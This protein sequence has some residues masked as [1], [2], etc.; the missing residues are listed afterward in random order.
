MYPT[1]TEYDNAIYANT[2]E[3][4]GKIEF[5]LVDIDAYKDAGVITVTSENT[6]SKKDETNDLVRNMSGKFMTWE[7]DS[8]ILD[9]SI[10]LAPKTSETQ[11]Q[12]GWWSD[13]QSQ[14]DST[15]SVSQV[16]TKPFLTG[17]DSIGLTVIFDPQHDEYAEE[18]DI[19]VY[20][21]YRTTGKNINSIPSSMLANYNNNGGRLRNKSDYFSGVGLDFSKPTI[22]K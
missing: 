9:G 10:V 7:T 21:K 1:T 11:F 12:V 19:E 5:E 2:I 14:A 18:F 4:K 6:I 16:Y 22:Y 8:T 17:Q 20:A 15:F 3:F 13:E